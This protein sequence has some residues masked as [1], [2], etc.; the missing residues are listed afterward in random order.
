MSGA[1]DKNQ[2]IEAPCGLLK[3]SKNRIIKQ[4]N[5]HFAMLIGLSEDGIVGAPIEQF[6]TRASGIFFG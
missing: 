3:I 4:C 1:F 2:L 6:L 5:H